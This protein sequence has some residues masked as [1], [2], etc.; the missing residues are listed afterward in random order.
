ME[1]CISIVSLNT[2]GLN[3]KL[4]RRDIFKR[5]KEQNVQIAC[6]QDVHINDKMKNYV[7]N[8][9]GLT[10]IISHYT[11]NARGVAVLFNNNFEYEIHRSKC[12]PNG[13]YVIIDLT[14]ENYTRFTLVNIYGPNDDSPNFYENIDT[15]VDEFDN[16]SVLMCGDWNLVLNPSCDTYNYKH[17]NNPKAREQ[18][19]SMIEERE[20]VDV[21]RAFHA[22]DKQYT[23]HHKNPVKM[24]RL[25]FFLATE[26]ILSLVTKSK[27]LTKYKSDHSPVQVQI[28]ISKHLRG[29]GNWKFNNSLLK[30]TN[31][32]KLIKKQ[33]RD[34]KTQY[35]LSPYNPDY[36]SMCPNKEIQFQI[37]DQLF[38]K[39]L[40]VQLRGTIISYS[41][42]KKRESQHL[43][44]ELEKQIEEL[45]RQITLKPQNYSTC[46][47]KLE[48][49]NLE[50]ETIRNE[51][52]KGTIIR[53]RAKWYEAGEKSSSY[54]CNLENRNF[55]NKSIQELELENGET[56]TKLEDI[57]KTQKQFYQNLYTNRDKGDDIEDMLAKYI[58]SSSLKQISDEEK[59]ARE[60]SISYRELLSALKKAKNNK[61]PGMDGY[62]TEFYKFFW[63]DLDHLLL[64]SINYAYENN[65]LSVSQQ[66]GIITCLPKPGKP[67]NQLKNWR[68]ISLLNTSY[69]LASSC[70]ADRIKTTLDDIIHEDQKGFIP[71][72]Y[73]GENTRLISD[74]LFETERQNIPGLLMIVDFEKA[75]DTVSWKFIDKILDMFNFGKSLRKWINIFY[76]DS[77]STIVQ[78]GH[79]SPFFKLGRGC[80]QGDPLSP[81]LF[82]LCVEIL[83]TAIRNNPEI[84]GIK[85]GEI[86]HKITQFADDTTLFLDDD[87]NSLR[88]TKNL[89]HWFYSIS[90]LKI[91][92]DKTNLVWIGSM[93]ESDRRFCKENN[94]QWIHKE[95]FTI[96]GI[97]FN[98]NLNKIE[99]DNFVPKIAKMKNLLKIWQRRNLTPLG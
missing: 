56:V 61:S 19:L 98:T 53:S 93:K 46:V 85:I 29:R 82:I 4:K 88:E 92:Y 51:K 50:L 55:V 80:R 30:D 65:A 27:I 35:A 62:T 99:Q 14:L 58:G 95:S 59:Q 1:K 54:F 44:I 22:T 60:G 8:E 21:W 2:R 64:R 40:L 11:S 90:G 42:Q 78:N 74:I 66:Q 75:F 69:K 48:E 73:I 17:V 34:I 72:R 3:D 7:Q 39:T 36:I 91:N 32:V 43:E 87:E 41:A 86:E 38:F 70:I 83:G 96:L 9:W 52:I 45:E 15:I 97:T 5:L 77:N 71:G 47:N 13:N 6:L 10:S 20:L 18:I 84:K 63:I 49:L 57:L 24:A 23:W 25:D 28:Q 68:P 26:D 89:F 33:I 76:K 12:D 31:F 79:F 81:Y 16:E 94:I 37:N 67:R